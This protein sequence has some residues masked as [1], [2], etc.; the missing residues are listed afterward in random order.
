VKKTPFL[1]FLLLVTIAS[2]QPVILVVAQGQGLNMTVIT[3]ETIVFFGIFLGCLFRTFAPVIQ[4]MRKGPNFKW[5]HRYSVTAVT[6]FLIAL[7]SAF[8]GFAGYLIPT[9]LGTGF[10]L[11][12]LCFVY[13]VGLNSTINEAAS[14]F[15]P[16][17]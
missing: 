5:D 8:I 16:A 1:I 12:I 6:S 7:V 3:T 4:D 11:F 9:N 2:S 10:R 17:T 13:G 15:R 14:W